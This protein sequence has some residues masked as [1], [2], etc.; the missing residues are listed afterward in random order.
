MD[1]VALVTT[2]YPPQVGGAASYF[3]SLAAA[4]AERGLSVSVLTTREPGQPPE[5]QAG[6]ILV[7]R[8]IPRLVGAPE[9]VRQWTQA[10]AT[11]GWLIV[12]RVRRRIGIVHTHGSKSVTVGAA[13]FSWAFRVPVV[14]EIQ[15]FF[16]RPNVIRRGARPRYVATGAAVERHLRAIGLPT[17]GILTITSIPPATS[18]ALVPAPAETHGGCRFV[19]VGEINHDVKG[20][21]LLLEAFRRVADAEPAATLALVGDGPDRI[22]DEVFARERLPHGRV[23][24]LG[25]VRQSEVL[26]V[27]DRS[28]VL[29]V[30][31]RSEGMPRVIL[32]AFSRGRPVIAARVGGVPEAVREGETGLLVPSGDPAALAAAMI[33]LARNPRLRRDLGHRGRDWVASL[34][35]WRDLAEAVIR[36]YRRP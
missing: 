21:D 15:D 5:S 36:L 10:L 7:V 25:A 2:H 27:L 12:L 8:R 13:A 1:R 16:S 24:F 35:G 19:F 6:R 26:A 33:T 34:P 17:D 18:V 32:E 29:V 9:P 3:S 28:D 4:L 31:S 20:T 23:E 14:Y 11:F 30:S 22:G